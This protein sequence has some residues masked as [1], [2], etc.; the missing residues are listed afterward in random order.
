VSRRDPDARFSHAAR[1]YE[2]DPARRLF[3]PDPT[4][5]AVVPHPDVPVPVLLT[6]P[7]ELE[8][9]RFEQRLSGINSGFR[10]RHSS[11]AAWE[12]TGTHGEMVVGRHFNVYPFPARGAV[13]LRLP[14]ANGRALGIEA[15][16]TTM[17]GGDLKMSAARTRHHHD[18]QLTVAFVL[19]Y[20][21]GG[22]GTIVGWWDARDKPEKFLQGTDYRIPADMLRPLSA[23]PAKL[24][25]RI[26]TK[27]PFLRGDSG[28]RAP[29]DPLP[30]PVSVEE[31]R[32]V[33]FVTLEDLDTDQ[34]PRRR[35]VAA[36]LALAKLL[37]VFPELD[38]VAA[39]IALDGFRLHRQVRGIPVVGA[40]DMRDLIVLAHQPHE[41]EW[42]FRGWRHGADAPQV[43][44][45]MHEFPIMIDRQIAL[46]TDRRINPIAADLAAQGP[47]APPH[48]ET[49]GDTADAGAEVRQRE[50]K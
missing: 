38:D 37:N 24:A 20:I 21:S 18:P 44:R 30:V 25:S 41:A 9:T 26:N 11:I 45:S 14:L 16:S 2:Y 34:E 42:V 31:R 7:I 49:I 15:R 1:E 50:R 17:R 12:Q 29:C 19:V 4:S 28:F 3:V 32:L 8:L 22:Q 46:A 13:D 36:K 43:V 33:G 10:L 47:V 40:S 5:A 35:Q 6:S 39:P 27:A 48:A 23:L